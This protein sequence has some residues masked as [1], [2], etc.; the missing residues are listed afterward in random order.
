MRKDRRAAQSRAALDRR[1]KQLRSVNQFARPVHGWIKAVREALGMST[2]QLARR[3]KVKQPTLVAI[4]QS[5]EKGTIQ[6]ATLRRAAEALD[7]TVVY[8]L[9]PN[10][11]LEKM[12][13]D[14]ARRAARRRLEAVDHTMRL[15]NQQVSREELEERLDEIARDIKPRALWDDE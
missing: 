2:P 9:V 4:E 3:M 7:C 11:P 8:A 14:R 5:E 1:F 6:L 12:V 10:Q 13:R 15:E